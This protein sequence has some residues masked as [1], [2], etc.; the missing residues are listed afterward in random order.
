MWG[1]EVERFMR[2]TGSERAQKREHRA[3]LRPVLCAET[4]GYLYF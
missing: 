1:A 2:G 3:S 4:G